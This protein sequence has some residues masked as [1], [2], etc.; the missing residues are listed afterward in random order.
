LL[1]LDGRTLRSQD[2]HSLDLLF[3]NTLF[4]NLVKA[5]RLSPIDRAGRSDLA[6]HGLP[7]SHEREDGGGY[8]LNGI[9]GSQLD[10]IFT[11]CE[12]FRGSVRIVGRKGSG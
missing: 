3:L 11:G 7:L 2:Q 9:Q 5:C 6:G 10:G 4:S 1:V 8:R 12:V